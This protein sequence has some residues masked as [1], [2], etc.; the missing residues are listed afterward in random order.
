MTPLEIIGLIIAAIAGGFTALSKVYKWGPFLDKIEPMP[1]LDNLSTVPEPPIVPASPIIIAPDAPQT[2]AT[3]PQQLETANSTLLWETPKQAWHSVRV[4]CDEMWLTYDQKNEICYT[5]NG[6]SE[7]Y[8]KA[9][10]KPNKNGTRD[11]GICQYNDGVNAK[12][13]PFWIGKGATFKDVDE[14]LNNPEK[15]V[16]VMIQTYKAGHIGWWYGHIGYS[17]PVPKTHPMWKLA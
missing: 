13:I 7:F 4:L 17:H 5:I 3:A 11:Y 6:E 12:G 15:C 2:P 14:V 10:G 16:R 1:S 8:I 9:I